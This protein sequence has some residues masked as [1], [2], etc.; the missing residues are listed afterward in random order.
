MTKALQRAIEEVYLASADAARPVALE[1][2]PFK[3]PAVFK[4]LL[5]L[6][7]RELSAEDLWAYHYSA[8]HTVGAEED[9]CYFLPRLLELAAAAFSELDREVIFSKMPLAGWPGKWSE[10]RRWAFQAYMDAVC[11]AWKE[12][13]V[14][15]MDSWVCALAFCRSDMATCLESLLVDSEAARANL[16]SLYETNSEALQKG[17]LSNAFWDTGSGRYAQVLAWFSRKDVL[18]YIQTLYGL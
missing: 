7:L 2:S 15:D 10:R 4:A 5:D 13:E 9:Y 12:I 1:M 16:R 18:N 6:P 17:R 11:A 8:I 14:P 3:D